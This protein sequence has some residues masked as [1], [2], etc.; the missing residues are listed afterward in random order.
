M[1]DRY[2]TPHHPPPFLI[3]I[4]YYRLKLKRAIN[5]SYLNDTYVDRFVLDS[6]FIAWD[7]SS[8]EKMAS[9]GTETCAR[10]LE[11]LDRGQE[12]AVVQDELVT[13]FARRAPSTFKPPEPVLSFFLFL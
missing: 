1:S 7:D 9:N 13:G 4:S 12:P 6:C 8:N 5:G 3:N 2:D 11:T 10:V